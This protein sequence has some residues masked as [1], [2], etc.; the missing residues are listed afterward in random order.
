MRIEYSPI[1]IR[2]LDRVWAE[3]FE[4][5]AS[6]ETAEKYIDDLMNQISAKRDFPKAGAPLYYEG[7]F[8]GFYFVTFKSYMAF[9][10]VENDRMLVSRVVYGKSD[11]MRTIFRNAHE[12]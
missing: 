4:A 2:D 5:S 7:M 10:K 8:A 12:K 1:A 6:E 9:Y 3:V 11:Y